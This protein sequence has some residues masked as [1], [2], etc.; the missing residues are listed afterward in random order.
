MHYTIY[1]I[2]NNINGKVYIG[3]HETKNLDDGY[4]GSGKLIVNAIS[5]YGITNFTKVILFDFDSEDKMNAKEAELVTEE[6]CLREDT[7]NLCPGGKGGWGYNNSRKSQDE[8]KMLGQIGGFANRSNHLDKILDGC[9]KGGIATKSKILS[10]EIDTSIYIS[11]GFSGKSHTKESLD[12][13]S[14]NMRNQAK[15]EC[16][17]CKK[18]GIAS[19]MK[20]WHF[21]NC[22]VK[23]PV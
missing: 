14:L 17:H 5:K 9:S 3:K 4:M 6:F 10:G 12:K 1:Q 11:N 8:R 7:Y 21:N 2:T 19:N 18:L 16:P 15:I 13:I 22:K 20:R 23:M